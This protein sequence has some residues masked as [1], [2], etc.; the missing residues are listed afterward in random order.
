M[1]KSG[2]VPYSIVMSSITW[3]DFENH[4]GIPRV[5]NRSA[6]KRATFAETHFGGR[7][8]AVDTLETI[9]RAPSPDTVL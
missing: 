4:A 7:K 3:K 8:V 2:I 1:S 5:A 6:I 9:K